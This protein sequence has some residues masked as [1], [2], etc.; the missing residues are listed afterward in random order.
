MEL[1]RG[2]GIDRDVAVLAVAVATLVLC[3]AFLEE[4]LGVGELD[5]LID[6]DW[7]VSVDSST[8]DPHIEQLLDLI[9]AF[10]ETVA[11]AGP[12]PRP[13]DRD[14]GWSTPDAT[15]QGIRGIRD[16]LVHHWLAAAAER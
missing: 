13:S 3:D 4:Q 9:E 7:L 5:A 2:A 12:E 1:L 16:A 14:P 10:R 15:R 8:R 11:M 6:E